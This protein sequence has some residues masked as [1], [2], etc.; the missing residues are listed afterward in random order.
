M[1][2]IWSKKAYVQG[3]YI[4]TITKKKLL[5]CLIILKLLKKSMKVLQ[6]LL[7]KTNTAD[8]NCA[9]HIRQ[10]RGESALSKIYPEM[11]KR[12]GKYKQRYVECPKV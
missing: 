3:F 4:E 1:S 7:I 11:G 2:N 9:G 12:T 8:A 6:N 10:N 5:I